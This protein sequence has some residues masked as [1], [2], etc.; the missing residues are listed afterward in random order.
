M[1]RDRKSR[2]RNRRTIL[3]MKFGRRRR[4][5]LRETNTE[6]LLRQDLRGREDVPSRYLDDYVRKN[7]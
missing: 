1:I 4:L 5:Q 3:F 2:H 6:M 7:N